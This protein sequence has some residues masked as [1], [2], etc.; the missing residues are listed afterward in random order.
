MD[1]QYGEEQLLLRDTTRGL[2]ARNYDIETRNTVAGT[3]LGHSSDVWKQL[4]ETGILGLG[5]EPEAG[6]QNEVAVVCTELGRRLALEPIV[7]A[8][9]G[10]G[11]LIAERGTDE[12]RRLLDDVA[13]GERL[14]ALAHAEPGMRTAAGEVSTSAVGHGDSWT[15]SGRKNPVLAGHCADAL[16]VS[17]ALPDGATGLFV[18]TADAVDRRGYRT[19]DGLRAAQ[20]DLDG[21]PGRPLGAASEASAALGNAV[22][23]MQS[24]LCAEALGAMEESLRLTTEYLKT[25]KQFGVTLNTF[26]ALTQRAAEMYVSLELARSMT[27]YAAMSIADGNSDPVIAARANL[28][29]ARSGRHIAEETIQLHGGIAMT[30][31]YPAGHYAARL[32]AIEHTLGTASEQ[33]GMLAGRVGDYGLAK[34]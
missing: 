15:L 30:D 17:A 23:R 7:A 33:L 3:E 1:F 29:I 4:A 2:L 20:I 19:F 14:L 6:G 5:F 8:A 12:Q 26:Q 28:Q 22:I 24:A 31:E 34:I 16:V 32:I 18:V 10:P 21:A 27:A 11:T 9:L 25:R 13:A